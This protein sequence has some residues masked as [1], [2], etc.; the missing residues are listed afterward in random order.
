M[1]LDRTLVCPTLEAPSTLTQRIMI[2]N[3]SVQPVYLRRDLV[4]YSVG[5]IIRD[6]ADSLWEPITHNAIFATQARAER[7]LAKVSKVEP[8]NFKLANWRLGY[9][10]DGVYSVL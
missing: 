6:C 1:G 4:G 10:W 2:R 5:A 8:W 9:S 3:L 7:F